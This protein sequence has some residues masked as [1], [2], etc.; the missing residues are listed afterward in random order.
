MILT[1]AL[2]KIHPKHIHI[3]RSAIFANKFLQF[4]KAFSFEI[5]LTNKQTKTN[6]NPTKSYFPAYLCLY[7]LLAEIFL[8]Y[9]PL[10]TNTCHDQLF[11]NNPG[12]IQKL[13]SS[14]RLNLP[15]LLINSPTEI[16]SCWKHLISAAEIPCPLN[17]CSEPP[18]QNPPL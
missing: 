13:H 10:L 18:P 16:S 8:T 9:N 3:L 15:S 17:G 11:C 6:Q 2:V 7:C 12:S 4:I 14:F 1:V 5:K